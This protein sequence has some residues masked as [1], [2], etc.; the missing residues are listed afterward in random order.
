M[1]HN[2]GVIEKTSEDVPR[3]TENNLPA[4]IIEL[5]TIATDGLPVD[6]RYLID[7]VALQYL[8]RQKAEVSEFY[9]TS[10]DTALKLTSVEEPEWRYVAGRLKVKALYHDILSRRSIEKPY[11]DFPEFVREMVRRNIYVPEVITR[12]SSEEL[13]TVAGFIR[14]ECDLDFDYAG[15]NLMSARYLAQEGEHLVELPQEALLT[16]AL[17][18]NQNE[19]TSIRLERVRRTYNMLAER[20][21]SLAT[22]ILLNLRRPGGNLSSCFIVSADD[23][24]ESIYYVIETCALISKQG[25]GVATDWS[26]VRAR[27]SSIKGIPNV[28]GGVLPW[29]KIIND[30]AVAV[31]QQGKRAG[32][33]TVALDIWHLDVEDFLELQT[34]NGDQRKKAFDVF[35]Q[36]VVTDEFMR[37]VEENGDWFMFDPH[38]IKTKFN[39]DLPELWGE[40]FSQI[41]NSLVGRVLD[42]GLKN[43]LDLG[44]TN[45]HEFDRAFREILKRTNDKSQI[46]TLAKK[47]KARDLLKIIMRTQIETG[48]PYIA[49]KDTINEGN[50]NKGSGYIPCV[51]L[52]VESY[53]NVKPARVRMEN[54]GKGRSVRVAEGGENHTCNLVSLNLANLLTREELEEATRE[55]VRMLDNTIELTVAPVEE[56]SHHNR[57]YR[58]IGIGVMGYADYTAWHKT[59]FHKS[60]ALAHELFEDIAF[61]SI[62]E[63]SNLAAERGSFEA[64]DSS[65][66]AK[67]EILSHDREWFTR[68]SSNPARWHQ[69]ADKIAEKGMRN[70]QLLAI[71]PNTS[72]ALVQGAT[73][74]MLPVFAKFFMDDNSK[75]AIPVAPPFLRER[76]WYYTEFKN[77]DQPAMINIISTAQKWI[78]TGISM[79]LLFNLNREN[80]DAKYIFDTIMHAWKRKSKA[81]YY[82]R[83]VQ[84]DGSTSS[85]DECVSCAG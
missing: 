59:P 14:P 57:L 49:F 6:A 45:G 58:T 25:G 77:I 13:E 50:P 76:F 21:I 79:E 32:S 60:E 22:P 1:R 85:K 8:D 78:D 10:V 68:E 73:A 46:I 30:T 47:V 69:L 63:S 9:R 75:G 81:I 54:D 7:G 27:G 41:Y 40:K 55:A 66:Y 38:E 5:L 67:G 23:Y 31:N 61:F 62:D 72:S 71:A 2:T 80:V 35:P 70:S 20:K 29:I 24:L 16:I 37:R 12:F 83:S 84:K 18:L 82:I 51:N 74:S 26:R 53:S 33:I 28:S 19:P 44:F 17:L 4:E 11:S 3:S 52:C 56:S 39:I 48:L 43:G 65:D 64:F 42:F 15:I 36:L 34:E